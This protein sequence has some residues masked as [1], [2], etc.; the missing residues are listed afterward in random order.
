MYL[1]VQI[2]ARFTLLTSD[3]DPAPVEIGVIGTR[4]NLFTMMSLDSLN[5]PWIQ[6][7]KN[8]DHV[9][10]PDTFS[11]TLPLFRNDTKTRPNKFPESLSMLKVNLNPLQPTNHH[12]S[13]HS[14]S[15]SSSMQLEPLSADFIANAIAYQEHQHSNL[16]DMVDIYLQ[17]RLKT[18]DSFMNW[19]GQ[20]DD[21]FGFQNSGV[22]RKNQEGIMGDQQ[23]GGYISW[24]N[25]NKEGFGYDILQPVNFN[26]D[27]FARELSAMVRNQHGYDMK[28][29]QRMTA[30]APYN[31]AT[32]KF[33]PQQ[34]Y[35]LGMLYRYRSKIQEDA[36][37]LRTKE[38]ASGRGYYGSKTANFQPPLLDWQGI[39]YPR[40]SLTKAQSEPR[41][42]PMQITLRKRSRKYVNSEL[43]EDNT[44][45]FQDDLFDT[46][47]M[48]YTDPVELS[49][50]SNYLVGSEIDILAT[51][52]YTLT[53]Y[54]MNYYHDPS[55]QIPDEKLTPAEIKKVQLNLASLSQFP[56][57]ETLSPTP[58]EITTHG[59]AQRN[60]GLMVSATITKSGSNND[61]INYGTVADVQNSNRKVWLH[62]NNTKEQWIIGTKEL[63]SFDYSLGSNGGEIDFVYEEPQFLSRTDIRSDLR[64]S[65]SR[66]E[67]RLNQQDEYGGQ[68]P[69][70][71]SPH[72]QEWETAVKAVSGVKF[73]SK[74]F[75]RMFDYLTCF[76]NNRTDELSELHKIVRGVN[77]V[78]RSISRYK[79]NNALRS[80]ARK[81]NIS[82][83]P[84]YSLEISDT[85]YKQKGVKMDAVKIKLVTPFYGY[86]L[87]RSYNEQFYDTAQYPNFEQDLKPYEF[88]GELVSEC[89]IVLHPDGIG[90]S[91]LETNDVITVVGAARNNFRFSGLTI[92]L[93]E[94]S[95]DG[96]CEW[97]TRLSGSDP[98]QSPR[99]Q[100][101]V[102][103]KDYTYSEYLAFHDAIEIKPQYMGVNTTPYNLVAG[104][105]TPFTSHSAGWTEMDSFISAY[106]WLESKGLTDMKYQVKTHL[107]SGFTVSD[108][109]AFPISFKK[110]KINTNAPIRYTYPFPWRSL[111]MY[112]T[113]APDGTKEFYSPSDIYPSFFYQNLN[114]Y[115]LPSSGIIDFSKPVTSSGGTYDSNFGGRVSLFTTATYYP[116]TTDSTTGKNHIND[117]SEK[118]EY[119]TD[120]LNLEQNRYKKTAQGFT[121]KSKN[122][123][124][125]PEWEIS[126]VDR[127]S[128]TDGKGLR[129]P[130]FDYRQQK[131]SS[132]MLKYAK[133]SQGY[134]SGKKPKDFAVFAD[135]ILPFA[136]QE[137]QFLSDDEGSETVK[138][139]FGQNRMV[140]TYNYS[141]QRRS[142]SYISDSF[143][144]FLQGI[145]TELCPETYTFYGRT[146][147]LFNWWGSLL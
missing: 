96:I 77:N 68:I 113:D 94:I 110:G 120:Y 78:I 87:L 91:I 121:F 75:Y 4:N 60:W 5:A 64:N 105:R 97:T 54:N 38:A 128:S 34:T 51:K 80:W 67:I 141:P 47:K 122:P 106:Q 108:P 49:N 63:V 137:L 118:Q 88:T 59:Y 116:K 28:Y 50:Y 132:R 117:T 112:V 139:K 17:P 90:V 103:F 30:D 95:N 142:S 33:S 12:N 58:P 52:C 130:V 21:L 13:P 55:T 61:S 62:A 133:D 131:I 85:A 99:R 65:S 129:A 10:L 115:D 9:Y 74:N 136:S 6:Y 27:V 3:T 16:N 20:Q 134:S 76:Y 45:K 89:V 22:V 124:I 23:R 73:K 11:N 56:A 39:G 109:L 1:K 15:Y 7:D 125:Y 100:F 79:P 111:N 101:A 46:K 72:W 144:E 44:L 31:L 138:V 126:F 135:V 48:F 93:T 83:M 127:N 102:A 140:G 41:R 143:H 114:D 25:S 40:L 123:T 19:I 26:S 71:D 35:P 145:P 107:R 14:S 147:G 43:L 29:R 119:V 82:D 2:P 57:V 66:S 36:Q 32:S 8:N 81:N 86:E 42:K 92:R 84:L 146:L 37:N 53:D 24:R 98:N 69:T 18:V 70:S 104:S